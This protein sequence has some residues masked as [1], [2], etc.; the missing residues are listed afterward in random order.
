MTILSYY[1]VDFL[2]LN[3]FKLTIFEQRILFTTY[4]LSPFSVS[5]LIHVYNVQFLAGSDMPQSSTSKPMSFINLP[6]F[7]IITVKM[8]SG[9]QHGSH[10]LTVAYCS[11]ST[12]Y[13]IYPVNMT[14]AMNGLEKHHGRRRSIDSLM[15][16]VCRRTQFSFS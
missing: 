11:T 13:M 1:H 3:Y 14:R 16:L 8:M 9:S 6:P 4:K 7:L 5:I 10:Q 2:N 12:S 15:L